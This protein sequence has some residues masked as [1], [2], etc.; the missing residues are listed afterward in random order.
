MA[1]AFWKGAI[2]FGMV[3]I[4]VKMY[5]ANRLATTGDLWDNILS[6]KHDLKELLK[7]G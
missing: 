7:L 5:V 2:S 1:K 3:T 4:P 6:E